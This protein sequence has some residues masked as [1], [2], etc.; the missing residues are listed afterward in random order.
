MKCRWMD[1]KCQHGYWI[2]EPEIEATRTKDGTL[3]SLDCPKGQASVLPAG[4]K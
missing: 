3:T 4:R 1:D 2:D